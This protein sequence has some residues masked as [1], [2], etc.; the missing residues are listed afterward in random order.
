VSLI[1]TLTLASAPAAVESSLRICGRP[2][3]LK[4]VIGAPSAKENLRSIVCVACSVG[5]VFFLKV[6]LACILRSG[7]SA[8]AFTAAVAGWPWTSSMSDQVV[9]PKL[10]TGRCGS[11]GGATSIAARP[12]PA[13]GDA[14]GVCAKAIVALASA[15]HNAIGLDHKHRTMISPRVMAS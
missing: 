7:I 5:S 9:E 4:P 3:S 13:D 2:T 14:T 1:L 8:S 6:M 15:K 10:T 12:R 11:P